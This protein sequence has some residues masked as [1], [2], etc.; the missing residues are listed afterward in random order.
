MR[1]DF[2][3]TATVVGMRLSN[4]V[5]SFLTE[6]IENPLIC[7]SAANCPFFK[8]TGRVRGCQY[9]VNI[10]C[11]EVLQTPTPRQGA[12]QIFQFRATAQSVLLLNAMDVAQCCKWPS[13]IIKNSELRF[14]T[15]YLRG[16]LKV[17][18]KYTYLLR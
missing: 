9:C 16:E 15:Y 8:S 12:V 2:T 7:K 1:A 4:C 13:I 5:V 10:S 11:S 17:C 6:L 18:Q 3:S 14:G